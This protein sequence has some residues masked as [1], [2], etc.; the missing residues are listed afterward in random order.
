MG[1]MFHTRQ[2]TDLTQQLPIVIAPI[3]IHNKF[4]DTEIQRLE[5]AM[6]P[7]SEERGA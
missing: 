2:D 3:S 5:I 6:F 1:R 4:V 7:L